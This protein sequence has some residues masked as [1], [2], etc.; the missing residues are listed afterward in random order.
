MFW[1]AGFGVQSCE[2][3]DARDLGFRMY[4]IFN[5]QGSG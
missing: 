5:V 3:F 4:G 2:E 1:P